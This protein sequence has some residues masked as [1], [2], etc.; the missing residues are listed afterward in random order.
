MKQLV[1]AFLLICFANISFA[2]GSD[3][4]NI[5]GLTPGMPAGLV[6]ET[7][8]TSA[9]SCDRDGSLESCKYALTFAGDNVIMSVMTW[10]SQVLAVTI[11][12]LPEVSKIKGAFKSKYGSPTVEDSYDST[13]SKGSVVLSVSSL[14]D[15]VLISDFKLYEKALKSRSDAALDD[16]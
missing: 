15:Q 13:W 10:D 11:N 9:L 7:L 12:D 16:I 6:A 4:L 14:K 8:G 3:Q 1:V 5:K 2:A